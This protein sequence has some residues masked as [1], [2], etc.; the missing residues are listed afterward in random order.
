M[1]SVRHIDCP[2]WEHF[3][4]V[5]RLNQD[6]R[7]AGDRL[8]RGH[9]SS[10]W[11]LSS[12]LE[13]WLDEF[14]HHDKTQAMSSIFADGA[15]EAF[16]QGYVERF[17]NA[18]TG[19]P[20]LRSRHFSTEDWWILGRHHGLITRLLD[21]T[22]SPYV[23]AYFAFSEFARLNYEDFAHGSVRPTVSNTIDRVVIWALAPFG[24][25]FNDAEFELITDRQED[26]HRQRA[27]AGVFTRLRHDV[28]LDIESY[29]A[30][31]GLLEYLERIE[32]PSIEAGKA[33]HA[34][35]LMNISDATLFPDLQGAAGAANAAPVVTHLS[36]GGV[37]ARIT[38]D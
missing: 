12:K 20:N 37:V 3:I 28:H 30:E 5:A 17:K 24:K 1:S 9:A 34:L 23:A 38:L 35:R 2:S 7:K 14:R 13:R 29:L 15:P 8:Y 31:R 16:E 32:I 26:F 22:W 33:L 25:V 19:I 21:W 6:R 4:Q 36:G 10:Q 27:Q 18:A 11:P